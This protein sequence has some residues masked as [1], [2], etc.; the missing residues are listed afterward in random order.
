MLA[1]KP[2]GDRDRYDNEKY[3]GFDIY[4]WY[5]FINGFDKPTDRPRYAN[6]RVGGFII[7]Q[8]LHAWVI[9]ANVPHVG[10]SA[11]YKTT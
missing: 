9:Q 8:L 4:W 7:G 2:A 10:C 11:F 6:K 1:G 3:T 5:A